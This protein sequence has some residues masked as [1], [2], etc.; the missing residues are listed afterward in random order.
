MARRGYGS[1]RGRTAEENKR[2][3]EARRTSEARRPERR[4][5]VDAAARR[6][7]EP[8]SA[9]RSQFHG[10]GGAVQEHPEGSVV[11]LA[12]ELDG[13]KLPYIGPERE[14]LRGEQDRVVVLR[15]ERTGQG[16]G[17][18]WTELDL[19]LR[20]ETRE[21]VTRYGV[22]VNPRISLPPGRYHL[23]IG[24][25]EAVG[26]LTG[27]VFYDLEVPDFRKEK[28]ML[29]GLLLASASASTRRAFSPIRS[30]RRCCPPRRPAGAIPAARLL[31]LYTEIYDNI[32]STQARR[33][34]V[35][36]RLSRR[37]APKCSRSATTDQRRRRAAKGV[38]HLRVQDRIPLKD[39]PPGRYVLRVE[40]QVRGNVGDA[41]PFARETLITVVP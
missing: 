30:S 12:I 2:D 6:A 22:R 33:I 5:D 7:G 36:A 37:T 19:T 24:A 23:R 27:S 4:Q 1:P 38:E 21:R 31:A 25:R 10:S 11:A 13:D 14:G 28:L 3:E 41:K 40:A 29:G 17:G 35:A 34:D 9:E 26:G 20:P 8:D 15:P 32:E 39:V 18:H 16:V